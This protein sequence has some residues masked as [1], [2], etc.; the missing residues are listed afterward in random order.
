MLSSLSE[1]SGLPTDPIRRVEET[2]EW[3]VDVTVPM[4]ALS[5][6]SIAEVDPGRPSRRDTTFVSTCLAVQIAPRF[7]S[8]KELR[9]RAMV[10][11]ADNLI[12]LR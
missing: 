3:C 7:N 9:R 6:T 2:E 1:D 12:A 5:N 11:Q 4:K 8:V 10:I